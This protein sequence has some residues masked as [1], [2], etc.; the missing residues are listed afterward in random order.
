MLAVQNLHALFA[1]YGVKE[2]VPSMFPDEIKL[3][4]DCE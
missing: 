4:G 2:K 3:G 1:F